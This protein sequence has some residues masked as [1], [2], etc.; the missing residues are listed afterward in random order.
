MDMTAQEIITCRSA[1]RLQD[2]VSAGKHSGVNAAVSHTGALRVRNN[3][4]GGTEKLLR[5]SF[6]FRDRKTQ[7]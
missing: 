3:G 4:C 2:K 6:P 7:T 5:F 1:T